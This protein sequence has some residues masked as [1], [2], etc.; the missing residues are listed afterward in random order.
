MFFI[1]Y[2]EDR[3]NVRGVLIIGLH[4]WN[5]GVVESETLS[6]STRGYREIN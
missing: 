1:L 2:H 4:V 3:I 6:C 5:M